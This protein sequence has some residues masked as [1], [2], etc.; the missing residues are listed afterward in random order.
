[1]IKNNGYLPDLLAGKAVI[2]LGMTEPD[3]GS[4]VTELTTN[5][6]KVPGGYIVN[7]SKVFS[8]HSARCKSIFDLFTLRPWS[9]GDWFDVD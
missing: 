6:K 3:A 2:S 1:M 7:G 9:R 8:T 4:A 5:A